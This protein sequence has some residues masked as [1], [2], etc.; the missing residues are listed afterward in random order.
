LGG[1]AMQT[2]LLV[3]FDAASNG[4]EKPPLST[5]TSSKTAIIQGLMLCLILGLVIMGTQFKSTFVNYRFSPVE[6]SITIAW[7]LGLLIL[8]RNQNFVP[9][10]VSSQTNYKLSHLPQI[11][12]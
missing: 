5:L 3:I 11:K 9:N 2:L 10:D 6:I 1:I 4:K 7:L 12:Y 8:K